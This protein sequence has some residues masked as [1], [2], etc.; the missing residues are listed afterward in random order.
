MKWLVP[1]HAVGAEAGRQTSGCLQVTALQRRL[2]GSH[3]A[4]RVSPVP[5]RADPAEDV[6]LQAV[7]PRAFSATGRHGLSVDRPEVLGSCAPD[8]P[9]S[10]VDE[11]QWR[12]TPGLSPAVLEDSK[13][14][15]AVCHLP[16][17]SGGM[18]PGVLEATTCLPRLPVPCLHFPSS[19]WAFSGI[20]SQINH[21]HPSPCLGL[22]LGKLA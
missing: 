16:A 21:R 5:L 22:C 10:A 18:E 6:P 1:G 4:A 14:R 19:L 7:C 9:R 3:L 15:Y 20:S 11:T 17:A 2:P 12:H 8:I 13:A